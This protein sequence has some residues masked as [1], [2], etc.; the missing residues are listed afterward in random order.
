MPRARRGPRRARAGGR[1][2]MSSDPDE[3]LRIPVLT[4]HSYRCGER[5]EESDHVALHDDLRTIHARGYT[6][7]P[8]RWIA[9]WVVGAR[10][11]PTGLRPVGICFDDGTALDYRDVLHPLFGPQKSFATILREF[12]AEIGAGEQPH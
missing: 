10:R 7:V 11:L 8:L 1:Q 6:I 2:A 9:Q 4:Y 12:A 3:E 5:Y